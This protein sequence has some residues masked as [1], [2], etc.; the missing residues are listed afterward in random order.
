MENRPINKNKPILAINIVAEILGVHQR[1]LRI[2]D[3]EGLL[4]PERNKQNRRLYSFND[5]EKGEF[6][7]FMTRSIG[8]NLVGVKIIL[9]LLG[10]MKISKSDYLNK[11]KKMAKAI[12]YD[13]NCREEIR[14]KLIKRGRSKAK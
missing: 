4:V 8:V 13:H 10:E 14:E 5:I 9:Y 7:Q 1:T 11:A 2:Y 12:G 6:I 3:E